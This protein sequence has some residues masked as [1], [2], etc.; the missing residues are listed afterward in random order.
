[1]LVGIRAAW[2]D[3]SVADCESVCFVIHRSRQL[4][5]FE[6]EGL[7]ES[8]P[9]EYANVV[10]KGEQSLYGMSDWRLSGRHSGRAELVDVV[11]IAIIIIFEFGMV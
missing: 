9:A 2:I 8:R 5:V 11:G 6:R 1:M 3:G 7:G 4:G 10:A